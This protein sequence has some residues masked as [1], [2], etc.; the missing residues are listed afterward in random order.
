VR[1]ETGVRSIKKEADVF[2]IETDAGNFR[3]KTV[4][5]ATGLLASPKLGSDGSAF[6][7]IK[8]F[9][10]HF[11]RIVP[12]LCGFYAEGMNFSQVAGVRCDAGVT[13]FVDGEETAKDTG[14]LQWSD[15][16]I[17]GIPV[18]Q[19]SRFAS[20]GLSQ[21]QRVEA[22]I[23]FLPEISAEALE[24]ELRFRLTRSDNRIP[25]HELLDGLLHQKLIPALLTKAGMKKQQLVTEEK[26]LRPLLAELLDCRLTLV[27]P[28]D[29]EFAQVCAGGIASG[30]I[31]S[32]TLMSKIVP[33]L[34]FC[35]ELLDVDG[36]CGGYNLQWAWSSGFMAGKSAME[37]IHDKN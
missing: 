13:I 5:F 23:R 27:K 21:K 16:G 31:H 30:D 32:G 24:E 17:S 34:F 25:A 2:L 26:Q 36:I 18:F 10:H 20:V 7:L 14:E 33:G 3:A 11:T 37:Y 12:A 29:Y 8:G 4:I 22:S 6:A 35:G 9:G 15:Y 28:R 1:L 19:V